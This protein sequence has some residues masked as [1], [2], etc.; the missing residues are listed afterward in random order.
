[1][2]NIL[3]RCGILYDFLH[4]LKVFEVTYLLLTYWCWLSNKKEWPRASNLT[5]KRLIFNN[6][7]QQ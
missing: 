6:Q 2:N 4:H 1:M 5:K 3:C 7:N